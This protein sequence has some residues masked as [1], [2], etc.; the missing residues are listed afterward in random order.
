MV[1]LLVGGVDK[2]CGWP[3]CLGTCMGQRLNP[4]RLKLRI[5]RLIN[6]EQEKLVLACKNENQC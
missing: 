6:N 4:T 1:V 3:K 2:F 5:L